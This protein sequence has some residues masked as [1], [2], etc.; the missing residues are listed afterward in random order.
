MKDEESWVLI[1]GETEWLLNGKEAK[2][3]RDAIK[4]GSRGMVV[5]DEMVVNIPFIKEFY[6]KHKVIKPLKAI[7]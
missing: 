7:E 3:L 4:Q 2:I 1:V 6:L 5:F